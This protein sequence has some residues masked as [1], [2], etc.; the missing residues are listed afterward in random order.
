MAAGE[1]HVYRWTSIIFF[2]VG[3]VALGLQLAGVMLPFWLKNDWK[4]DVIAK[5]LIGLPSHDPIVIYQVII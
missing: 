2:F 1:T 5:G 4:P 3:V